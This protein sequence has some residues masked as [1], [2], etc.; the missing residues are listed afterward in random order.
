V[1]KP[2]WA[3]T[4]RVRGNGLA[5]DGPARGSDLQALDRRQ[6]NGLQAVDRAQDVDHPVAEGAVTR[7]GIFRQAGS[8]RRSRRA[9][10][11]ALPGAAAGV[12]VSTGA[13]VA[14]AG[15]AAAVAVDDPTLRSNTTSSFS[16]TWPTV[17]ASIALAI[18]AATRPMSACWRRTYRGLHLKQSLGEK[19][20]ICGSTMT[21]LASSLKCTS[22]GLRRVLTCPLVLTLHTDVS[23]QPL[24][25]ML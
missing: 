15:E 5:V 7:S 9:A 2:I 25:R 8:L 11:R 19:T 13:A 23:A 18:M 20:D 21:S 3:E 24:V 1:D 6:P 4:G 14:D 12:V 22:N 16:A 17:L 10:T